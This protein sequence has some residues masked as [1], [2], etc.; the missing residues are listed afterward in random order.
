MADT[1]EIH[2]EG[3]H[4][5]GEEGNFFMKTGYIVMLS[6]ICIFILSASFIEHVH[7]GY[8]HETGVVI[9]IGVSISLIAKFSGYS[10]INSIL[11]F[12]DNLFFFVCLPPLV[13]ASGYNMKRK[14][15]F[16]HFNYISLFGILGTFA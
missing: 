6:M 13:F 16:Q 9:L 7:F 10:E 2:M 11:E 3:E 12:N 4:E 8:I 5:G 1:G 15:F 14:K